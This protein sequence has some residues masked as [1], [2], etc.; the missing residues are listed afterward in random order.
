MVTQTDSAIR[1]VW[2]KPVGRKIP[3]ITQRDI[4]LAVLL[5]GLYSDASGHVTERRSIRHPHRRPPWERLLQNFWKFSLGWTAWKQSQG[6]PSRY[7]PGGSRAS[8]ELPMAISKGVETQRNHQCVICGMNHPTEICPQNKPY[9]PCSNCGGDHWLV[10]CP[11]PQPSQKFASELS[12]S[13]PK[14]S[15]D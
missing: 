13:H 14:N 2:D 15:E 6:P 4:R 1:P 9:A 3:G 11:K 8:E 5:E 7:N 12:L 10:D